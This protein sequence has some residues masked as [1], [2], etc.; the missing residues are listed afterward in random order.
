[1]TTLLVLVIVALVIDNLR[2][3]R[4][5]R[6][7]RSDAYNTSAM[8]KGLITALAVRK[9]LTYDEIETEL[10]R[11]DSYDCWNMGGADYNAKWTGILRSFGLSYDSHPETLG[12]VDVKPKH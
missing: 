2:V 10:A 3:R 11:V 12:I 9:H 6:R 4:E 5:N 1:M 8:F 7:R